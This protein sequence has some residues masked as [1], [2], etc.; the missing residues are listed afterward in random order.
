MPARPE[1]HTHD[2]IVVGAGIAGLTAARDLRRAGRSVLV[3]EKSRGLGGRA[4]TRR[5]DHF[6]VDHGAQFFTARSDAFRAQ[7][8]KWLQ[9]DVCFEWT[10]GLHS[11]G[12][13]GPLPPNGDH[14]PRYA[15]HE[16]MAALGRSLAGPDEASVLR[17][18]TVTA[19]RRKDSGWSVQTRDGTTFHSRTLVMTPP[20]PQS[21]ALLETVSPG[22]AETLSQVRMSP[23]LALVARYDRK[24]LP[25]RG[26]QAPEDTVVSWIGHDTSKRPDLHPGATIVVI[27]AAPSFSRENFAR[28]EAEVAG[29]LL[30]VAG[31]I[32]REDLASPS[33]FFLQ[34]WRY[35]LGA[36]DRTGAAHLFPGEAPLVLAGDAIAGGKI[37]GAWESG[38]EA[39]RLVAE[40]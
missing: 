3:L 23:C 20:P 19:L 8:E 38:R 40:L 14:F 13:H 1:S 34:R 18:R 12:L 2:V 25:W 10:R 36:G 7:A 29:E 30:G 6:P 17:E 15:C 28:Q 27:H 21:A 26:I 24:D 5:W 4:A 39:A 9:N 33:A 37:E 16:G 31:R 35:A 22:A 32:A 11:A